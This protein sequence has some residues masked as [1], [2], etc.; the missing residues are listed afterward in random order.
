[1]CIEPLICKEIALRGNI[2]KRFKV[3]STVN[4]LLVWTPY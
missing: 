3:I 2:I 1:M 4:D